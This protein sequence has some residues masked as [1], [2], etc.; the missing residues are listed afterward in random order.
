MHSQKWIIH[1][2][3]FVLTGIVAAFV[4]A[5][6]LVSLP[7]GPITAQAGAFQLRGGSELFSSLDGSTSDLDG[8]AD[9]TLTLDRMELGGNATIII[10]RPTA[11]FNVSGPVVLAGT[12][13]IRPINGSQGPRIEIQAESINLLGAVRIL[14]DG[15]KSG[16]E[17]RLCATHNIVI[18]GRA[19]ISASTKDAVGAG[20]SVHLEA[21]GRV[22]IQDA[23]ATVQANGGSGGEITLISCSA[24]TGGS[25]GDAAISIYGRI[26]AIGANGPGGSVEV[27]ARQG[28]VAFH[29]SQIAIDASGATQGSV[30]ITAATQV[31]PGSPPTKPSSTVTTDSP[32]N[33]LCDCSEETS[34]RGLVV[35]ADV[36]RTAGVVG[37]QFTFTGRVVESISPVEHWHWTLS[38]GR[39]LSGMSISISFSTPG[40]Y[41]A[42][43]MATDQEGNVVHAETGVMVFDP[44]TQAPPQLGLP[45]Q[46]GDVD[47]DSIITLRDAHAVSKHAG[48]LELLPDAAKPAADVDLDD[49][50]TPDDARLLGQAVAAGAPLPRALLPAR[51]APGARVNLIS[52]ALLD[53][54]VK[55]EIAVGQSLWIQQPLR[56]V[57][58]YATI[59]I[60]FDATHSGSMQVTPGPVQVRILANGVVADTLTFQVEA[61]LPL[62]ANPKAE[63]QKLLDDY[64]ALFQIN[65]NAIRQLL[66]LSLVDGNE[67]ELL[68]AV[69]TVAQEDTTAKLANM[70]AVLD[71]PAGEALAELFFL[72]AN[73]NGYPELRRNLTDL[74]A[75]GPATQSSIRALA[76]SAN[77]AS[78][79]EI[80][81]LVCAVKAA[82]DLL[83]GVG[84]GLSF[85]C[86]ALLIAAVI[87]AVVPFDGP[88]I[89]ATA[90]FAW[91]SA[92]GA[93]EATVEMALLINGIVGELEPDLRFEATPASPQPGQ[94]V[95]LRATIELIGI[96]EVCSYTA[97]RATDELIEDLA[98]EAIERMLRKKFAL[99]ALSKA[100]ELLSENLLDEL[101]DRLEQ[102]VVRVVNRTALGEALQELTGKVCDFANL[103]V[104][105]VDDL[106][107][108]MQGPNPNVGTTTF[109][110]DGTADFTCPSQG[111]SSTDSV[112][113]TAT[114][115]LC[116]EEQ[117]KTVTVTCRSRSVTITMGDNGTALDD[118]YEVRIQGQTVLTS[119]VPVR[120]I[121]TTVNLPA[122]DHLIE[123]LGR[124][125]PDGIGTYFIQFSGAT[126]IGGAP[127]SGTDLTPGVVKTF[128]IRVQ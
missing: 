102:A 21:G 3:R 6:M 56:F 62:P 124:A 68:L 58:G 41:G 72:F 46:I 76:S 20:G 73:A 94:T 23:A 97:G 87:G 108:I 38:D 29:P 77:A 126:V 107:Q 100:V 37:T 67:R 7:F 106:S 16:G 53:P 71:T 70:R 48:R 93:I 91:A 1:R 51:G 66:D 64:V 11:R 22:I 61:P 123:M 33:E 35:S 30:S 88:A 118:I 105:I 34:V 4:L 13:V 50:V 31:V 113:F 128:L 75:S 89:E 57:R 10:D 99:R 2:R 121:S 117:Q 98:E 26:E 85:T 127:L 95:K 86:D 14:A 79:D 112:T 104:P 25:L 60:P 39:E 63:L 90:L 49:K 80:V 81:N 69:Y 125:A 19:V 122:G 8:A 47:G 15:E 43:L 32:S 111:S 45:K 55:I 54:T 83:E 24:G 110:G 101:E 17:L 59:V 5:G 119:S 36:D 12:S 42:H 96:D 116:D 109:P 65:Q 120:S 28:G 18:G 114:R 9:G 44:N 52:P 103:G 40:P 115:E 74:L 84:D 92:C 78:V 27:R 82:A